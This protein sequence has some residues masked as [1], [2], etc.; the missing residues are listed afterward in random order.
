SY[1]PGEAATVPGHEVVARIVAVG[2]DVQH[3]RLGERVIVQA[4]WRFLR[5]AQSN[6]A[7]GYN[8]EG[9]LQEY[10]LFD[11]QVVLEP[12]SRERYLLP[13]GEL[14]GASALALVEPWACVE[15]SYVTNERRTIRPA[16]TLLVV[17]E[18]GCAGGRLD[19]ALWSEGKPNTLT[20]VTPEES[21]SGACRE[22]NVPVTVV[23]DIASLADRAFDDIIYFGARAD[24]V[25]ALGKNLANRGL[26][27]IVQCGHR[28]GR[29]VSVDVGGVHYGLTRWCGT[30]GEDASAGYR[31]IP[32]CGEVRDGDVILV[33]GAA[34][35]MG[36]MHV[37]R[38]LCC[39]AESITL[40]ASDID[41][42]RL[43]SLGARGSSLADASGAAF[44]L[45]N[46][47]E[48]PSQQ[49]FTYITLMAPVAGLVAQAITRSDE[50]GRINIFAG[51]PM[52]TC[53]LLDLDAY[54]ARR[55]WMFG[56]S[57]STIDDMQLVLKKVESGQLDTDY[58]V[59]AVAGMA[60]AIDGIRA[61]EGRTVAGKI[62]V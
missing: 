55:L 20:V 57:G 25:E 45:M 21:V 5:T 1:V 36:Q 54:I 35:P 13:V 32:D 31:S 56:T 2:E 62:I 49:K 46:P 50:G 16:G 52:G 27:N 8:F 47:R 15:H 38:C 6:A 10:V 58:S 37:I 7:F 43:K 3:H 12:E 48:I 60:G 22:L 33:V 41:T 19:A 11:E 28:F 4:D 42:L 23:P 14:G 24:T 29:P 30:T 26:F 17:I 18:P 59:G 34:G 53:S 61:V 40:V 51:I 39:G 9:G 44:R